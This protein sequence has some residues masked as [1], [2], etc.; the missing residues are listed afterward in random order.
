MSS[1]KNKGEHN[2][3]L[4]AAER[5]SQLALLCALNLLPLTCWGVYTFSPDGT[6]SFHHL[7]IAVIILWVYFRR[8]SVDVACYS[9]SIAMKRSSDHFFTFIS[10]GVGESVVIRF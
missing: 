8:D 7:L 2:W 1:N 9:Y 5:S 3:K 4:T 10:C 6:Q